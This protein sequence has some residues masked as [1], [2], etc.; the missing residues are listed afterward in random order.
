MRLW[1]EATI[2]AAE[3]RPEA[4]GL[5][6]DVIGQFQEL[7]L[8]LDRALAQLDMALMVGLQDPDARAQAEELRA[9]CRAKG[10]N[11]VLALLEPAFIAEEVEVAAH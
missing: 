3:R 1:L 7:G 5:F 9:T 2:A 4:S 10:W 11:G 6:L 8:G